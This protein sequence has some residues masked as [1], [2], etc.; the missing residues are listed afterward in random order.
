MK[1]KDTR[2]LKRNTRSIRKVCCTLLGHGAMGRHS[3]QKGGHDLFQF[4]FLLYAAAELPDII[5][6]QINIFDALSVIRTKDLSLLR[7]FKIIKNKQKLYRN[8]RL[9]S[10]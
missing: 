5:I 10:C 2:D 7:T 9:K 8:S 3:L 6:I 1:V 4:A